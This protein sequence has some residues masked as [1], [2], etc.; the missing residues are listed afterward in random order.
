M[1]RCT[2]S[3]ARAWRPAVGARLARTLVF[4]ENISQLLAHLELSDVQVMRLKER[5]T[6]IPI[7]E[8]KDLWHGSPPKSVL[9]AYSGKS[10]IYFWVLS[11]KD[12]L[13]R[14]YVGKT[15]SLAHRIQNYSS[16]FQPHSPNDFKLQVFY[17]FTQELLP[18]SELF[19]YF[20]PCNVGAL[21]QA[22]KEEINFFAPLLNRRMKASAE[23]RRKLQEAF[24][25]YYQ[26]CFQG[27]LIAS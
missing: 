26:S 7:V 11:Y 3:P 16:A 24:V 15:N 25:I 20:S 21:T 5:Y 17:T 13:H 10:G 27:A 8:G 9:K 22:E 6:A 1:V 14:I 19:L 12:N 18:Q 2:F 23:I 4:M